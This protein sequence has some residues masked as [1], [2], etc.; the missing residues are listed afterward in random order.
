MRLIYT[1]EDKKLAHQFSEF[2]KNER[3]ENLFEIVTN[4]DWGSS[5]YGTYKCYVWIIDE[6][7]VE[8]AQEWLELYKQDPQR[9]IFHAEGKKPSPPLEQPLSAQPSQKTT[10]TLDTK[11]M[12]KVTLYVLVACVLLFLTGQFTTPH[13][14]YSTIDLPSTPLYSPPI[15]KLLFYDYPQAYEIIDKLV[16]VYGIEK[17]QNLDSLP[18]EG[19]VLI[20]KYLHTPIWPGLYEKSVQYLSTHSLQGLFNEPMF[21]KIRQGE[22]WRLFTP[23]LLHANFFHIFFNMLW[24]V[25][26]GKL[27]EDRIG[28][29]RYILVIVITAVI[30]N[31]AQYL[32]SG[33]NF[34]GYS[35]VICG[36]LAFIWSRQRTAP[37]ESYNLAPGIISF[38]FFFVMAMFGLQAISFFLKVYEGFDYFPS[39]ANTAHI[40]GG[41]AGFVLGRFNFMSIKG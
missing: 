32:I 24:L 12:G 26:L 33:P 30:S 29:L 40:T 22:V 17:L 1:T 3:I 35:G 5:D 13:L 19:L 10:N 18:A 2:L 11:R 8:K 6:E 25:F 39:I 36:M 20:E 41:L 37:W 16:K 14:E 4:T 34:V 27:I 28:A 31:T 15:Y 38:M 21:E 9:P 23:C 7:Q